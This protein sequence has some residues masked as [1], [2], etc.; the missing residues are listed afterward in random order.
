MFLD[1]CISLGAEHLTSHYMSYGGKLKNGV[2]SLLDG[3]LA[4]PTMKAGS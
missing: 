2:E 1:R 4:L 3:H